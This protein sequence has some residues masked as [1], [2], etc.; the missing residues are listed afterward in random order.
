MKKG[1]SEIYLSPQPFQVLTFKFLHPYCFIERFFAEEFH[2]AFCHLAA[3][4]GSA[5]YDAFLPV[6]GNAE[7]FGFLL[8]G[9]EV[10]EA[11]FH[12][13]LALCIGLGGRAERNIMFTVTKRMEVS[14]AHYLHLDYE[15]KCTNLHGHNWIIT[16]TVQS[17][18]VDH[19]GMV[20]DFSKIKEIVNRFDH[21]LINDVMG[22]INPTAENMA[23]WLCDRIPHCVRVSVQETEGNVATYEK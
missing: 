7:F 21:A 4:V 2:G 16:V 20:V 9:I 6:E 22:D 8:A 5:F 13:V 15:S 11:A 12:A 18:E 17:E 23:K 3:F 14:G 10:M 1:C 19:N